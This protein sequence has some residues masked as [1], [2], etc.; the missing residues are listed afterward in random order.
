MAGGLPA[1]ADIGIDA[2]R[3]RLL[4]PKFTENEV[5]ILPIAP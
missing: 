3:G 4:V 1:P 2:G 5:L